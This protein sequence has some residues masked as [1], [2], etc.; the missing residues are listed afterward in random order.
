MR[1]LEEH[2]IDSEDPGRCILQFPDSNMAGEQSEDQ[3]FYDLL[4]EEPEEVVFEDAGARTSKILLS[5]LQVA[6]SSN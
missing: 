3:S 1:R 5:M 6:V 2:L 4:M